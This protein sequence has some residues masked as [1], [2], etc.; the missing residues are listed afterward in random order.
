ME[1]AIAA[2]TLYD[3]VL[4]CL[5]GSALGDAMGTATEMM[6]FEKIEEMFGWI[7]GLVPTGDSADSAR[8]SPGNPAGVYSDDTRLKH[9]TC[10]AI[11]RKGGRITADDLA[12]V[13]LE[14]MAGWYYTPVV[15]SYHK[16]FAGDARPREAG[17]GSMASNSSAMSISPIGIVNACD[18]GQA[19]QDAY[20]VAGLV[21]EG[22][23]RDAACAVASAV[24]SAFVPSATVDSILHDATAFLYQR[25]QITTRIHQALEL[26]AGANDYLEFRRKYYELMLLPW[27]QSGLGSDSPPPPGFYDTA[28]PRETVPVA[29]AIFRLSNGDWRKSVEFAANFGRD[30]DTIGAIVGAIAGAYDGTK[31]IPQEWIVLVNERNQQDQQQLAL[32]MTE[33]VLNNEALVRQRLDMLAALR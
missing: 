12:A 3:K 26:A 8:F 11:L 27:P 7:G 29:L 21:H 14:M 32:R 16:V 19:A 6:T 30:S 25:S 1:K 5:V 18:P 24:A 31:S 28:E 13:W 4:G 33:T 2:T 17:R 23:A 10:E 22:Y 15:N 9:L 20:D